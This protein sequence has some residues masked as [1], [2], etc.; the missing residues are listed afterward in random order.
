MGRPRR[1][2]E[3]GAGPTASVAR[4]AGVLLHRPSFSPPPPPRT[5]LKGVLGGKRDP[6]GARA[7][8][9]RAKSLA[10]GGPSP[11]GL[12]APTRGRPS[13]GQKWPKKCHFWHFFGQ[14]LPGPKARAG[15]PQTP[16]AQKQTKNGLFLAPEN[17]ASLD[18]RPFD[19]KDLE[20]PEA[21][22]PPK[23]WE[24][25]HMA[26]EPNIPLP[27]TPC[28]VR[29]V[30]ATAEGRTSRTSLSAR[31]SAPKAPVRKS[32]WPKADN[33]LQARAVGACKEV[34]TSRARGGPRRRRL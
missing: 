22:P 27:H 1:G 11:P 4:R 32:I 31:K 14:T 9:K 17:A 15:L 8:A 12:L 20:I 34:L 6:R 18:R 24:G 21:S 25:E 29:A 26:P 23:G 28:E 19:L 3:A 13:K 10:P 33:D 7:R 5:P 30:G 2:L 16:G